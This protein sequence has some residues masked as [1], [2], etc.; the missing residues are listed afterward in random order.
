MQIPYREMILTDEMRRKALAVLETGKSYGG[1]DTQRFEIELARWC[2]VRY[3]VSTNSGTSANMLAL[4]AKGIGPGD[5]VILPANGYVSVL[6]CVTKIGATPVFVEADEETGNISPAAVAAALTPHTRAVVPTHMYGFPCDMDALTEATR[7]REVFVL[8]DAAHALGAEYRGRPVGGIGDAGFFSFSG[9]MITVFGTGGALVTDDRQLAEDVSSLRDQG[10]LRTHEISFVRRSDGSWYDQKWIGYNMH[11]VEICAALGRI[12]LRMLS[13]FL[14]ARR[15]AAACFT[16]RFRDA[17]LP[18][19]LP[20]ERDWAHPSYLHYVIYT[21]RR[22]A[23]RDF[24]RAHGVETSVHYPTPL[25]LLQPVRQRYGT[26]EGQFPV[27]E[28]LC[29]DNLS[30]PVGPHMTQEMLDRVAD[31]VVDFFK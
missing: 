9:K 24:L 23:L 29:R 27:A 3:G 2:G 12:Q 14:G 13:D 17:D 7:R 25:H 18:I 4:E 19:R 26:R 16:E 31:G 20:I 1:E 22:D 30:L 28:R 6:G 15:K 11:L 10:R 5:E 21:P 8:E